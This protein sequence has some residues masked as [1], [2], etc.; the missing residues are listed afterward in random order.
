MTAAEQ[1]QLATLL[2]PAQAAEAAQRR[3]EQ[4]GG[5][6]RRGAGA[7]STGLR[8]AAE[9]LASLPAPPTDDSGAHHPGGHHSGVARRLRGPAL[10]LPAV[11]T[12]LG[13]G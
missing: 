1:D 9:L 4:R 5:P 12:L 7:G 10:G 2:A 11:S 6:R 13:G 8:T 3:F